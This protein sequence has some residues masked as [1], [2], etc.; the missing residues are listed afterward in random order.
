VSSI[1]SFREERTSESSEINFTLYYGASQPSLFL[2][3]KMPLYRSEE[4]AFQLVDEMN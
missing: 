1:R 3:L 4:P 2:T